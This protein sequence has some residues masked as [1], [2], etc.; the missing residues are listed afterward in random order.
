M[1]IFLCGF[2][3]C[4]KS[5]IGEK[6]A[7]R[8]EIPF[9]DMDTYIEEKA[10]MRIPEIF[11]QHG[12]KY[13]R[14]LETEAVKEL[15]DFG[16]VVACGGGAMLPS[17]NARIAAQGGPVIYLNVPFYMCYCR[18]EDSDRP[19]VRSSTREE[20][21]KLYDTRSTIYQKRCTAEID[22]SKTPGAAVR[23]II[24]LLGLGEQ[25]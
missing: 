22:A 14:A 6:L 21:H 11:A 13:F 15:A 23:A 17:E 16:G 24:E 18:I 2:M 9:V 19:I 4:G 7:R 5:T 8:L 3:G 12:E 20:L 10:G 25:Q 1:T